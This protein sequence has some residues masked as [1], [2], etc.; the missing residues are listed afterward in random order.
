MQDLERL[1]AARKAK[2]AEAAKVIDIT[3]VKQEAS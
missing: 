1:Q 3:D 2:T